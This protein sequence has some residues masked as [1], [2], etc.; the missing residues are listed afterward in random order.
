[1]T[2][3]VTSESEKATP[4][5]R[6]SG[7]EYL[8][9]QVREIKGDLPSNWKEILIKNFPEYNT[10]EGGRLVKDVYNLRSTDG[11]LT[12]RLKQIAQSVPE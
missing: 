9:N 5:K 1:M 2:E 11:I 10:M 12:D 3:E 8:K 6:I 7:A 4:I